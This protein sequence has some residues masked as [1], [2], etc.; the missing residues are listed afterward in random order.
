MMTG[1]T[2]TGHDARRAGTRA[3]FFEQVL[4]HRGPTRAAEG[5]GP[6][7]RQPAL[8][9]EDLGPALHVIARQ[10]QRVV[11]LVADVLGQVVGNPLPDLLPERQ[12]LGGEVQVHGACLLA[13]QPISSRQL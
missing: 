1:A 6:A 10:P 13:N 5:L 2:I 8:L 9:A 12:F 3:L 7:R 11:H 4:L